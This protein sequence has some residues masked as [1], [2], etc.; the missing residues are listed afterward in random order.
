MTERMRQLRLSDED[1]A[2]E[3]GLHKDTIR[4]YRRL[5]DPRP[6]A[7]NAGL[8]SKALK[9]ST[10]YFLHGTGDVPAAGVVPETASI[11]LANKLREQLRA[12]YA[13]LNGWPI[14]RID[15]RV[16]LR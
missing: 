1:V 5:A 2:A 7:K 9:C 13:E 15:I 11:A 3:T 10:E 12:I 4:A 8:V 6:T 14:E 16:E